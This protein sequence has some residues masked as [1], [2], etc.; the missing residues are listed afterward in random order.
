[1]KLC[2]R[3]IGLAAILMLAVLCTV[4]VSA[5]TIQLSI[6]GSKTL[7][8]NDSNIEPSRPNPIGLTRTYTWTIDSGSNVVQLTRN[9]RTAKVEAI[10]YGTARVYCNVS[11][12]YLIW[13]SRLNTYQNCNE[14]NISCG[15]WEITVGNGDTSGNTEPDVDSG[16]EGIGINRSGTCGDNLTWTLYNDGELIIKGTGAMKNWGLTY[17]IPW[18][19]DRSSIKKITIKKGVTSIGEQAF[20]NCSNLTEVNLPDTVASIKADAFYGCKKLTEITLP[21]SVTSIE[22][23]SFGECERL[24][25]V[26]ILSRNVEFVGPYVTFSNVS[27]S[28]ALY[29]YLGSTTYEYAWL[30]GHNF[31]SID[32]ANVIVSGTCGTNLTWQLYDSGELVITGTGKMTDWDGSLYVP[33]NLKSHPIYTITINH[34]VTSI[35]NFAFSSCDTLTQVTIPDSVTSIGEYAFSDC[36]NLESITIP[37]SVTSIGQRAFSGCSLQRI[38]VAENNK[39]FSC[40]S[41]GVLFNKDKTKLICYPCGSNRTAYTVPSGVTSIGDA[42]F[43]ECSLTNISIPISVTSIGKQA[44]AF[45]SNLTQVTVRST[46]VTFATSVFVA[47]PITLYGYPGSTTE[48]YAKDNAH[49][50]VELGKTPTGDITE[51]ESVDINDA[52]KLFQYSLMP[53]LYPISYSGDMDFNHDGKLD[54]NDALKLFQYSLMPDLYPL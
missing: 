45:C 23:Y 1:M 51:D 48:T 10:G 46:N 41:Y 27:S 11:F 34:G 49:T 16:K 40:D 20:K 6:T 15:Y 54:I 12:D 17:D 14:Y 52:L 26:T 9:G 30:N 38:W 8:A 43:R 36:W 37:A 2:K 3:I 5:A 21:E 7:T 44:F 24:E 18:W 13:D 29:G 39:Y 25:K 19:N 50:F 53:D 4:C 22:G 28:F 32:P 31:V 42:A 47:S 35:G 33:W